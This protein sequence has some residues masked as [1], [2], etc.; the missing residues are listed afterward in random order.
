VD[1]AVGEVRVQILEVS[2]A[3]ALL[4]L[5]AA[6]FYSR[7]LSR[8]IRRVQVFAEGLVNARLEDLRATWYGALEG[9]L[10]GAAE[11]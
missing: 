9:A 1:A 3:A 7:S 2:L 4:A 8:R 6:Y 5:A 11:R 10:R